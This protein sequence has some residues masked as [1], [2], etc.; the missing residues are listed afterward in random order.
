MDCSTPGFPVLHHLPELA[1]TLSWWCHPT[2]SSSVALFSS[3]PQSFPASGLFQWVGSSHQVAKVLELQCQSLNE[4]SGLISFRIDWFD[5]LAVQGT[6]KS[7]FQHHNSK[8]SI[9]WHSAF[10]VVQLS[11]LYMTTGKTIALTIWMSLLFNM[12]STFIIAFLSRSKHLLIL[13][14]NSPFAVI[15]IGAQENK[16]CHCFH[17]SP[18]HLPWSDGTEWHDLSFLNVEF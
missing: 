10:F 9:L 7:L 3:C 13:W 11:Q 6:L 17:F 1:Q 5:L 2:I 16:I 15:F 8:P 12:L 18:F 4:Y 14:L